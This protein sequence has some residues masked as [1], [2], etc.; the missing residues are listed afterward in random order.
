MRINSLNRPSTLL[1]I[2]LSLVILG[3][4]T[5][6][7]HHESEHKKIIVAITQIIEHPSLDAERQGIVTALEKGGYTVGENFEIVYQNAQGNM[8]TA[9]Q[10]ATQIVSRKPD[11][12]VAISTPSAQALVSSLGKV[13]IPLVFTAVTDPKDAKLITTLDK[14]REPITGVIDKVAM[15]PQLT[16]IQRLFPPTKT[17]GVIY[18]PGE[19]NSVNAIK[20]INL[21]A[22]KLGLTIVQATAS[23]TSD[24]SA[25]TVGL[26][27]KV[28]AIFVPNDNTAVSAIESILVAAHQHGIPVFAADIGSIERG[29]VAGYVYDR[30]KLGEKAG[31]IVVEILKGK[32]PG[33]IPIVQNHPLKLTINMK[34][35]D[36]L[37]LKIPED[38]K[39]EAQHN[40]GGK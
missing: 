32:A 34:S 17:I 30:L 35:A 24:V 25:A 36:T 4:I 7:Y 13:G 29:A 21:E 11:I 2:T 26:I 3:F 15:A 33:D 8:T 12:V 31:E 22:E 23:R 14:R 40:T 18:N 9:A 5:A 39:K 20:E 27:G 28:D 16:L 10:I 38:L 6:F 19:A 37:R 1:L